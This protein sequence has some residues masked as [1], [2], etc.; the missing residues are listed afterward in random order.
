MLHGSKGIDVL[1]DGKNDNTAR[2]LPGA[3]SDSGTSDQ[4]ALDL[5]VSFG[6]AFAFEVVFDIAVGCLIRYRRDGACFKCL[7]MPENDLCVRVCLTLVF[8]GEVQVDI[9]LLVSLKSQESFKRNIETVLFFFFF[10][11][12]TDPGR[13]VD[14]ALPCVRLHFRRVKKEKMAVGTIIMGRK[15]IDFRYSRHSGD[16]GRSD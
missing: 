6:D 16:K 11:P 10:S 7:F 12:G 1:S 13:K 14:P 3:P 9:G 5:T 2:V 8:S 4:Q 15:R